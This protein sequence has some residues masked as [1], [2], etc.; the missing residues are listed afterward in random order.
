MF[1]EED[2][3]VEELAFGDAGAWRG[4]DGEA[5]VADG[6]GAVVGDA[7]GGA[8]APDEAPPRAGGGGADDGV[9]LGDGGVASGE[10]GGADFAMEFA[11]VGVAE[12][13]CE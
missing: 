1:E 7:D 12:E 13:V 4:V 3:A 6:D 9:V 11:F 5:E 2:V 8:E 10:R